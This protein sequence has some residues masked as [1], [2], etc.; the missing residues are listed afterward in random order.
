VLRYKYPWTCSLGYYGM[1]EKTAEAWRNLWFHTGDALKRD[2]EGWYY[3]VDRYKDALRRRGEN[4]SSYEVEQAVLS[5]PSVTE[6]TVLGVPAEQEA[7]EDEVLAVVVTSE[8]VKPEEIWAWCQGK[9]P[10]FAMPRFIRFVDAIPR[11]PSE[12][13]RKTELRAD[14]ITSDTHDR[15]KTA[16]GLG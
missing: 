2:A 7:G 9:V 3:F 11:T 16:S 10:A 15:T 4:I 14:G 6:C 1:P 12:K 8:P 5:F 13:V